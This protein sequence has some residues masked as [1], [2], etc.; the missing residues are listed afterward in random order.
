VFFHGKI[1]SE[2]DRYAA[3]WT[4]PDGVSPAQ[5]YTIF[6]LHPAFGR[7]FVTGD[8]DA[9]NAANPGVGAYEVVRIPLSIS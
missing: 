2:N 1:Y 9:W 8:V 4:N 5:P 3:Q 6:V 7:V